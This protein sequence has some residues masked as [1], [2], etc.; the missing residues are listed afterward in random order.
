MEA[1]GYRSLSGTAI[2]AAC[3]TLLSPLVFV[4]WS[5][6]AVPIVGVVLAAVALAQMMSGGRP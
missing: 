2:A 3:V 6:L 5:F 1:E 4:G